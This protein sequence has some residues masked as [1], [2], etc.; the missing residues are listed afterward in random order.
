MPAQRVPEQLGP[1][2]VRP[3]GH[4]VGVREVVGASLLDD[5]VVLHLIAEGDGGEIALEEAKSRL[6]ISA[7]LALFRYSQ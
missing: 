3:A 6:R 1:A 4:L 2:I 7:T 5:G